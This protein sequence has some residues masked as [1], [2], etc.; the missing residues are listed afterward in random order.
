MC[1]SIVNRLVYFTK[2]VGKFRFSLRQIIRFFLYLLTINDQSDVGRPN[3]FKIRK[4]VSILEPSFYSDNICTSYVPST[5]AYGNSIDAYG[6]SHLSIF[7]KLTS[8][9]IPI[10]DFSYMCL[11]SNLTELKQSFVNYVVQI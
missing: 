11:N 3:D 5:K 8:I 6:N 1:T 7:M 9:R 10:R 2:N 4:F